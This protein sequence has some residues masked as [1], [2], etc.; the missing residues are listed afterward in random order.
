[1]FQCLIYSGKFVFLHKR[2]CTASDG[3]KVLRS[4]N[5]SSSQRLQYEDFHRCICSQFLRF[6]LKC[7]YHIV[8]FQKTQGSTPILGATDP[9]HLVITITEMYHLKC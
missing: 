2:H 3:N 7:L 9:A 8:N 5:K 6:T 1:M 4:R